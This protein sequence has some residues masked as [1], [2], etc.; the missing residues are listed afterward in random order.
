MARKPFEGAAVDCALE[1]GTGALNIDGCR[2]GTE[3][4]TNPPTSHND[5]CY[6]D[7]GE[8][9]AETVEGR[10]PANVVFDEPEA[11]R[12]DR[13]VGELSGG[14]RTPQTQ[15]G[16]NTSDAGTNN[17]PDERIQLESGGPSRYFYTSKASR[18]ERTADGTIP[19]DHPTVKPLDLM[20][21]LV[22]MVTREGQTVLD[23][24][25]GSGTTCKA[26]K[27]LGRAFLGIEKQAKWADVARARVGLTPQDPSR[28]RDDD[29]QQGLAA[30]TDGGGSE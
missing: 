16:R 30:Y 8:R 11:E 15:T 4:H 27:D 28:V 25:A 17:D 5:N 13:E 18:A 2:I 10:Y 3:E 24:F 14:A 21:W 6:A 12:L 26:A 19:N 29:A 7:A 1:H 23:P 20:E 9:A 22:R